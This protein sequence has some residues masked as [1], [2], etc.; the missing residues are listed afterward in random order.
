[1][2]KNILTI[3]FVILIVFS[4]AYYFYFHKNN[5]VKYSGVVDNIN[6]KLNWV[7]QS[8][9][10]GNYV[11]LDKGFY[12]KK[13]LEVKIIPFDFKSSVVDSVMKGE[14]SFGIMGADQLLIAREQGIPV[15]AI[16]VIYKTNPAAMYSLKKNNIYKPT[17][18]VGK[19]IG[20]E[21]GSNTVYLYKA[22]MNK[23]KI[24]RKL[25]KEVDIGFDGKEILDGTVDASTSFII[26]EPN[27]IKEKGYDV[28]TILMSDY[29]VNV[30]S[31]IIFTTED[32]I[33]TNPQLVERFLSATLD[34]WQYV[35]ENQEEAVNIVL[36][37]AVNSSK[38]HEMDMLNDSIPL[39]N[40]GSS[41][42]G[43]MELNRWKQTLEVLTDQG[44]ISKKINVKDAFD[45]QFLSDFYASKKI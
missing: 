45:M 26:N 8:E 2:K 9:Y 28:N 6:L 40:D 4:F 20:L 33:R 19:T 13:G 16:A 29:G 30:Y 27:L 15:K 17:D 12:K 18:F 21:K 34:G 25:V 1:M 5:N 42:L 14:A 35:F 3:I 31:D 41:S 22:M 10:A 44:I 39:I 23:L 36:K 11:A 24:D 38:T 32:L 43:W 37:Y 7:H